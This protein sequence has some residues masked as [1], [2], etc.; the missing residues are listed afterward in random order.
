MAALVSDLG[1]DKP[2]CMPRPRAARCRTEALACAAFASLLFLILLR[3]FRDQP[4]DW[5]TAKRE[6]RKRA[7]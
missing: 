2:P 1:L 7:E 3:D 6:L 5:D 4:V